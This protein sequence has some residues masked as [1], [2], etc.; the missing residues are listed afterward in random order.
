MGVNMIKPEDKFRSF[1][2]SS[3]AL[4]TLSTTEK[5]ITRKWR[6][7][8]NGFYENMYRADGISK[9]TYYVELI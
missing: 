1:C 8:K 2:G 7:R 9:T 4:G 5:Y 3:F 6:W